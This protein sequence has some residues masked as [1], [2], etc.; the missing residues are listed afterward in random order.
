MP[1]CF[2]YR[3][4]DFRSRV[5]SKRVL[6]I[7]ISASSSGQL[8]LKLS[9]CFF[10]VETF[11]NVKIV[12]RMPIGLRRQLGFVRS[13]ETRHTQQTFQQIYSS[14]N[15]S[16]T[17]SRWASQNISPNNNSVCLI[18]RLNRHLSAARY[19]QGPFRASRYTSGNQ[20]IGV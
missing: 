19:I 13:N 7:C 4:L 10:E 18:R 17:F 11:L 12:L 15:R 6:I 9:T 14:N 16:L 8:G 3:P 20:S 2:G 5:Y 1:V